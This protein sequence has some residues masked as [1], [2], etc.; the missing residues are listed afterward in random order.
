[1][2]R[3]SDREQD[4]LYSLKISSQTQEQRSSSY[5]VAFEDH[6]DA[7]NF[8]FLLESFFEDLGEFSADI[9]PLPIKVTIISC[10]LVS[11]T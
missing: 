7:N 10:L 9:I 3:G 2:R 4:R 8:C 1:M 5:I 6:A 11:L